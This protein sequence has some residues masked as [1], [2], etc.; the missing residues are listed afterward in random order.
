MKKSLIIVLS[1]V[2]VA[3]ILWLIFGSRADRNP[4]ADNA[5]VPMPW[6]ITT[7]DDGSSEVFDIRLGKTTFGDV[8]KRWAMP[9]NIGLFAK[10]RSPVSVEVWYSNAKTG[11]MRAGV[12]LTLET[13]PEEMQAMMS[14]SS[15]QKGSSSGDT[16]YILS[17]DDE[18][19][20]LGKVVDTLTYIPAY[21]GL[22][23]EYFQEHLGKPA[24]VLRESETAISW[25]YPDRGLTL[26]IDDDGKDIFQYQKPGNFSLPE[27][28]SKNHKDLES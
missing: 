6:D 3:L 16:H 8:M 20:L 27:A 22:E 18:Q 23:A 24:A 14:R 4:E 28:T 15:G 19:K 25:Y 17:D 7:F 21:R 1:L 9:D 13:S 12:V 2:M 10:G 26:T 5:L 11:P